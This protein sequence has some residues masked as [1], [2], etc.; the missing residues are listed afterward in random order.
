M[1]SILVLTNPIGYQFL[2]Y[3]IQSSLL[4]VFSVFVDYIL[5]QQPTNAVIQKYVTAY[6]WTQ[7]CLIDSVGLITVPKNLASNSSGNGNIGQ[8]SLQKGSLFVYITKND[9]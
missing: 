6:T 4:L 5:L 7:H 8:V 3:L 1:V 2:S 9:M